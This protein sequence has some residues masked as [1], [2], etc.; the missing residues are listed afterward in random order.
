MGEGDPQYSTVPHS[1]AQHGTPTM[2]YRGT[3]YYVDTLP[4]RP[5][6]RCPSLGQIVHRELSMRRLI[7]Y[8][9]PLLVHEALVCADRSQA[10]TL[11]PSRTVRT[12]LGQP[13]WKV[14]RSRYL[15]TLHRRP[16]RVC[17]KHAIYI[18]HTYTV[19]TPYLETEIG[20]GSPLPYGSAQRK[21]L[22]HRRAISHADVQ[23]CVSTLFGCMWCSPEVR[24]APR[25]S[26]PASAQGDAG[27]ERDI[28]EIAC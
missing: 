24:S 11:I 22:A 15:D 28:V 17:P 14:C 16:F 18:V 3:M 8:R 12:P 9:T 4:Y 6:L 23:N 5:H 1:T 13:T 27:R 2:R 19:G 26:A 25:G 7:L 20:T 10:S 21:S